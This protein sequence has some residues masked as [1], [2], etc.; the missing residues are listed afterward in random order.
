[1]TDDTQKKKNFDCVEFMRRARARITAE[2]AGMT[3]EETVEWFNSKQYSDPV[4]EAM[5]AR[6]R[7]S[8]QDRPTDSSDG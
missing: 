5:A 3:A 6:I 8:T 4:L 2:I 7:K 1:M